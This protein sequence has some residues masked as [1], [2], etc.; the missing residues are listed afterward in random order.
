MGSSGSPRLLETIIASLVEMNLAVVASTAGAPIPR[1]EWHNVWFAE[2]LPGEKAAAKAA[3]V[4][5][6][7]GSPTTQQALAAGAAVIGLC[8]NMDQMLNMRGLVAS[9]AGVAF[10]V[11]R[12]TPQNLVNAVQTLL[13]QRGGTGGTR[14]ARLTTPDFR[15]RFPQFLDDV[16]SSQEATDNPTASQT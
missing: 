13:A 1:H 10:R 4:I 8:E 2:Y 5:C 15:A 14:P 12:M 11:D 7:G 9:G 3:L 16:L 6:N